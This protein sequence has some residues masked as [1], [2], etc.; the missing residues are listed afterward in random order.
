MSKAILEKAQKIVSLG[1]KHG[2]KNIRL[3]GS[4]ARGEE[5]AESDV[6]LLYTRAEKFSPWFP[7]CL[8]ID[9]EEL[10]GK[11]VD[12]V[13]DRFIKPR[14]KENITQEAVLLCDLIKKD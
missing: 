4:F 14:F 13:S 10:L 11:P 6:D 5:T 12:I 9:L 1:E 8:K 3:F 7:G 2:A